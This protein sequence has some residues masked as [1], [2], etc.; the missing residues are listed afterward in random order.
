MLSGTTELASFERPLAR[1]SSETYPAVLPCPLDRFSRQL[2]PPRPHA[3]WLS[4]LTY[5]PTWQ[6]FVYV[7]F[8]IDAYARSI[9]GWRVSHSA[10]AGFVLDER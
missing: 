3:L 4:D 6:C 1:A 10:H 9:V 7:A 2:H 8:I 5:V